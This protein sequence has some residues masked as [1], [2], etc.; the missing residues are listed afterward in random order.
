MSMIIYYSNYCEHS[1]KLIQKISQSQIVNDMH[2]ICIDNRIKKSN[3]TTNIILEDGQ[4]ILL[5]PTVNKVP[6][7]LL[8][9]RGNQVIFGNEIEEHIQPINKNIE[10]KASN[11]NGEP[12]SYSLACNTFGVISDNYSFLDQDSD[13]LS[14]KGN[15]GMRQQHHYVSLDSNYTIET[16]PDNYTPDKVGSNT[17]EKY[18]QERNKDIK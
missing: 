1:K 5:P 9:N 11:F 12:N 13:E 15:G 3:G 6:A 17:L 10:N 4:E 18:Q 2:F 8:L 14:A 16:P 7:L